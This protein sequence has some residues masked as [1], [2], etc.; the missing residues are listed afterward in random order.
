MKPGRSSRRVARPVTLTVA[1]VPAITVPSEQ[2]AVSPEIAHE[3]CESE[4]P[5]IEYPPGA[6]S[7]IVAVTF[8]TSTL[9]AACTTYGSTNGTPASPAIAVV[10][11]NV[12]S[13]YSA[14]VTQAAPS[15]TARIVAT[16]HWE[17]DARPLTEGAMM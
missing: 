4:K 7:V 13:A 14:A 3:P 16:L 17:N 9:P 5:S 15:I 1:R 6:G 2:V 12:T 11:S 8:S 10:G